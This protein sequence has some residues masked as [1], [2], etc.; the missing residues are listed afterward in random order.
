MGALI[1]GFNFLDKNL[2]TNTTKLNNIVKFDAQY[3]NKD[4]NPDDYFG[5]QDEAGGNSPENQQNQEINPENQ[6]NSNGE[7]LENANKE[8]EVSQK[9]SSSIYAL[10]YFR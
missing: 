3:Y 9:N 8:N 1:V 2:I 7:N 5:K 4:M 10:Y 6:P